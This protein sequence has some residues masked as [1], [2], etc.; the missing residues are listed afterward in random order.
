MNL[1]FIQKEVLK[2]TV[3]LIL[4]LISFPILL[5]FTPLSTN[6]IEEI[7]NVQEQE[8]KEEQEEDTI[9]QNIKNIVEKT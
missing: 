8:H 9:L 3:C 4:F 7:F 2:D 5:F 1:L 6:P